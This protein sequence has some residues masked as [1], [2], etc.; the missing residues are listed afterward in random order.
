MNILLLSGATPR[1]GLRWICPPY[2]L[3]D[4]FSNSSKFDEKRQLG[5]FFFSKIGSRFPSFKPYAQ[6]Y[7]TLFLRS[8]SEYPFKY[9]STV[10]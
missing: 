10:M 3:E 1:G 4:Q 2:F 5:P 6:P 9:L 8:L 7:L